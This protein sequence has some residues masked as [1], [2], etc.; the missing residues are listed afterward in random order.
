MALRRHIVV[1]VTRQLAHTC[2]VGPCLPLLA[3]AAADDDVPT[4]ADDDADGLCCAAA[5]EARRRRLALAAILGPEAATLGWEELVCKT[6]EPHT[7]HSHK[8]RFSKQQAYSSSNQA[9]SNARS[10]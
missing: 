1:M 4:R 10:Q 2:V 6:R 5:S 3:D 9:V 7:P 8:H